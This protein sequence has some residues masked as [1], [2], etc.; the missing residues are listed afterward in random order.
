[1]NVAAGSRSFLGG[2]LGEEEQ[3]EEEE[4]EEEGDGGASTRRTALTA[5]VDS[6]RQRLTFLIADLISVIPPPARPPRDMLASPGPSVSALVRRRV[7]QHVTCPCPA[8]GRHQRWG[9]VKLFD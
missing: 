9:K 1:M 4:E 8:G 6:T 5:C 7:L 2:V 3:G